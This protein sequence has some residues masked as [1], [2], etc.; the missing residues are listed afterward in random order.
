MHK[1][2]REEP[3]LVPQVES[4]EKDRDRDIITLRLRRV[5][6]PNMSFIRFKHYFKVYFNE[7]KPFRNSINQNIQER[8]WCSE[9]S[10]MWY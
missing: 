9:T 4:K 10:L 1:F 5:L 8:P 2:V 7:Y 6:V 3:W